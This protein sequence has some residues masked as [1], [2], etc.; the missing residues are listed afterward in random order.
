MHVFRK[1]GLIVTITTLVFLVSLYFFWYRPK[2]STAKPEIS[3]STLT[4]TSAALARIEARTETIKSFTH[5]YKYNE[6][7]C[8]LIDMSIV[9]GKKR[10][11]VFD[12]QKDS[13]VL[14]GL[15]A[16]GRCNSGFKSDPSFSIK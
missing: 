9:S 12:L 8:F 10:F 16:H 1:T 11:F 5:Q 14:A 7:I 3:L 6:E 13:I 4:S 2:F 15:V